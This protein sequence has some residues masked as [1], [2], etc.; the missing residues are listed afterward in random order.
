MHNDNK[1]IFHYV[2]ATDIVIVYYFMKKY[3]P[4]N[5]MFMLKIDIPIS[6]FVTVFYTPINFP[7][8]TLTWS[9]QIRCSI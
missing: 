9:T 7:C 4:L 3:V 2:F 8:N 5:Y 6:I 1:N